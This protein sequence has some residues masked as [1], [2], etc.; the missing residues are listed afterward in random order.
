[1]WELPVLWND[2]RRRVM[3]VDLD[4]ANLLPAPKHK[5]LF[6]LSRDKRK[7]QRD[8]FGARS[9]KRG[10]LRDHLQVVE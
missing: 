6:Q 9:R 7:R 5:Q 3:L 4:R 10:L 8:G 2:E 1:M